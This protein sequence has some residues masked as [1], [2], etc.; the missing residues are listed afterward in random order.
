MK[1]K[2]GR[3][4]RAAQKPAEAELVNS[5]M[6]EVQ[7]TDPLAMPFENAPNQQNISSAKFQTRYDQPKKFQNKSEN[8]APPR[9]NPHKSILVPSR[10]N[11]SFFDGPIIAGLGMMLVATVW[12]SVGLY[13][14]VIFF[15]PPVL[16]IL[17]L[18]SMA[19][20]LFE[21]I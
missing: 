2:C 1:C 20:G 11:T 8:K 7:S 14:G 19:K 5:G 10:S 18:G 17:G 16:F 3:V 15:Y 4:F 6:A 9:K 12:F 21:G 13:A